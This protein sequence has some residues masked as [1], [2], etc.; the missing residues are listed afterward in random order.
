MK[1]AYKNKHIKLY[2]ILGLVWLVFPL[3]GIFI[4]DDPD[5]IDYSYLIISTMYLGGYLY[6][7][8]YQY[9]SIENGMLCVNGPL[10]KKLY[11]KDIRSIKKFAG[12]YILKSKDKEIA[13]N[14][15]TM[16]SSSQ[17]QLL[18]ELEKLDVEWV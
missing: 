16:D 10:G 3:V 15:Q 5:W 4:A 7:S 13:I 9:L 17:A 14:I 18:T 8:K 6:Q 2:L 1:I 11:L 12:D